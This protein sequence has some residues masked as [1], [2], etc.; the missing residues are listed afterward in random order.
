[1]AH[2]WLTM[3]ILIGDQWVSGD[4]I[5]GWASRSYETREECEVRRKFAEREFKLHALDYQSI[6]ICSE[7]SPATDIIFK[8]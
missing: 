2:W 4:R 6:W 5:D 3:F 1:M 8:P 7:Q